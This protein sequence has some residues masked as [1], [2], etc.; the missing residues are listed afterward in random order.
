MFVLLAA[1]HSRWWPTVAFVA[2]E[3]TSNWMVPGR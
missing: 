1:G 3:S 2:D